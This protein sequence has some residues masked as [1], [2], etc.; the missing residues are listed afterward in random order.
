MPELASSLARTLSLLTN[1][2]GFRTGLSAIAG[3]FHTPLAMRWESDAPATIPT[4]LDQ[5]RALDRFLLDVERRAYRIARIAVRSD[6]DALDIVQDAMLQLARRY[7]ARTS[8]EWRPLFFRILQNRIRD[9]LRRRKVRS[10]LL[11][12][13]PRAQDERAASDPFEHVAD[14][15]PLPAQ[16]LATEQAMRMLEQAL[17][18]L[19]ARQQE[20]FMLRN[21]EGLD[22]A[23]TARAMGCSEG[24]VKTH[25]SRAVH[26]LRERLG[27]VWEKAS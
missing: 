6:D 4:E 27:E 21:F 15:A 10:K 9:C 11:A 14:E 25:Y 1:R 22:V 17:G 20:A 13:L 2:S 7:G 19:P 3:L 5:T 8:D 18:V 23:E 26:A 24:S 12:W 16:T